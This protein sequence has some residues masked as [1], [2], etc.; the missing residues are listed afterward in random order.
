M[1]PESFDTLPPETPEWGIKLLEIISKQLMSFNT[2]LSLADDVSKKNGEDIKVIE[3]KL[4]VV[5]DRNKC[6]E[7]ENNNLRERLL[8]IEFKQKRNNLIFEGIQ[9]SNGETEADCINK[10]RSVLLSVPG[11]DSNF[12]V[13]RCHRIDGAFKLG[14][15]RR[16]LCCFNWFV[17]VQYILRNQKNLPR[18]VFVNEDLPEEWIDRRK[19]LRPLYNAAKRIDRI[20]SRTYFS[21]DKLVID[22]STLSAGPDYNLHEANKYLNVAS[23]CERVDERNKN[24][25]FS[26]SLSPLSNLAPATFSVD[27]VT[28]SSAEQYIQSEKAAL[29]DDDASQAKIMKEHNPYKIKK[30][31]SKAK[32]FSLDRWRRVDRQIVYKGVSA[33]FCQNITLQ[34][35]LQKTGDSSLIESTTDPYWGSGLS[36]YNRNALDKNFW[37]NK[38]GSVM[39]EILSRV[40]DELSR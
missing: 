15:I 34:R 10:I 24:I 35:H 5:E 9:E 18:G 8:D 40:R 28:Y 37:P 20:K 25:L 23:T 2:S 32:N 29:F 27:N 31:S 38:T 1:P 13:D 16:L 21:K 19:V 12:K 11:L 36:L 7:Y 4:A 30:L 22:S 6:L 17:D 26:G 14:K 39:S 33:K 3:R